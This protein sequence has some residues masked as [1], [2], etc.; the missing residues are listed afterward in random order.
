MFANQQREF[1]RNSRDLVQRHGR[2]DGV[3]VEQPGHGLHQCRRL[4]A[5]A[6]LAE[7]A[8][9]AL[10]SHPNDTDGRAGAHQPRMSKSVGQQ[11]S[12]DHRQSRHGAHR[13]PQAAQEVGHES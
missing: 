10:E 13:H 5:A 12:I 1:H 11:H 2:A 7:V 4:R 6:G 9:A 3:V 8:G